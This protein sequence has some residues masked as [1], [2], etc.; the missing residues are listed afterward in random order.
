[1]TLFN[2]VRALPNRGLPPGVKLS[3]RLAWPLFLLPL[4]LV[5]QLLTPHP[6]WMMLS[7][8]IVG[9]YALGYWW[10]REQSRAVR[11][12][13]EQRGAILV[14]GDKFSEDFALH[15]SSRLPVIWAEIDDGSDLPGYAAGRVVAAGATSA[16]RW[17]VDVD[18]E[19]RGV[20]RIG[21]ASVRLGD[22]FGLFQLTIDSPA[23]DTLLIYPRVVQLPQMITL[24]GHASGSDR[25]R[26]NLLG[27][28]P[29]ASVRDYQHGDSLRHIH[30]PMSAHRGDL[31]VKEMELEPAGDV[32]I[33]LDLNRHV[34]RGRDA[35][36]TLEYAIVVAASATAE[37]LGQA[38]QRSV[39]LLAASAG[40]D[41]EQ[42][43]IRISPQ[44][45]GAQLWRIMAAL[46]PV[47][48]TD[49]ELAQ[50]LRSNSAALGRRRSVIVV[51]PQPLG[52]ELSPHA[53]D[54]LPSLLHLQANGLSCG[55]LLIADDAADAGA[56]ETRRTLSRLDISCE[57]L[58][59]NTK[60]PPVITYRRTRTEYRST[61]TGG[62]IVREV[63]EEVG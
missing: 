19:R 38:E 63:E 16:T 58:A 57:I 52:D 51:T 49:I 46:A 41:G 24:R 27:V 20:Y 22:P 6:I 55:V 56:Q 54:W 10:L 12:E 59:V 23:T 26:Q 36:S 43:V 3:L 8:T 13:R 21:P 39:G 1:M 11:L 53:A 18:C 28:L 44:A 5:S 17:H 62:V 42:T 15:N 9:L 2:R 45:G 48:P 29:A 7:I 31:I 37:L 35:D 14:A 34:H 25:R 4:F 33:L 50:L 61:P 30:W 60:L 32:W 47:R 40:A